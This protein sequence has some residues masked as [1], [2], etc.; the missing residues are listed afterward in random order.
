MFFSNTNEEPHLHIAV[1]KNDI[2]AVKKLCDDVSSRQALNSLGFSA[3]ELAQ[4]LDRQQCLQIL[5]PNI[6]QPTISV[7]PKN[8]FSVIKFNTEMFS[9]LFGVHYLSHLRFADYKTLKDVICN[10][11]W[12]LKKSRWGEEYRELATK[13]KDEL[14][15]GYVADVV[16]QWIDDDFGYGVFANKDLLSGSY[17]GE[18]TGFI[19]RLSRWRPDTNAY[20][21]KYPMRLLT[22]KYYVV[23]A[24]FEGNEMRFVNHSEEPNLEPVCVV[25]RGLLHLVFLT[26]RD[27][28][29]GE[30]LTFN[31]GSDYWRHRKI[32][33]T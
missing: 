15:S 9:N 11:P 24:M 4:L 25:D 18:Y 22:W 27:I 13:Y 26:K 6:P 17:V 23:D 12:L 8:K 31:Y 1:I 30:E 10:C 16:L 14:S 21:F 19:R 32:Q 3:L 20:C 29:V 7:I 5:S 2:T 33:N 28:A